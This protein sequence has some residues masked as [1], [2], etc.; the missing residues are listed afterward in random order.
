M[1]IDDGGRKQVMDEDHP[2]NHGVRLDVAFSEL[3]RPTRTHQIGLY[4]RCRK[5]ISHTVR[6]DEKK[7]AFV[8]PA[9]TEVYLSYAR[10][11]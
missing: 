6:E 10:R 3:R 5:R 7:M 9:R 8:S 2:E 4:G 1:E 11:S